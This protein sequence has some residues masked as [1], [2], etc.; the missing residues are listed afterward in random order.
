MTKKKLIIAAVV[1]AVIG[2]IVWKCWPSKKTVTFTTRVVVTDTVKSTVTATGSLAP[3]D[4]VEV[5]TQVSGEV[6]KIYVDYNSIVKKGQKLAELDKSTLMERLNQCNA[7]LQSALSTYTLAQ[8]NYSRTKSLYDQ[9]AATKSDLETVQ[10]ALTQ[11]QAQVT[12]AQTNV[13]EAKVNLGYAEIYSPIDGV[14]LGKAVEEGQTVASSFNTPTLFTIARDLKNMQVEANIDEADIGAVKKGQNVTFTVDSH[15][16][17]TFN[18]KVRQIRLDPKTTN[19][20]VTYTVI[21]EAPN[22]DEK[23]LPGMTASI[24]IITE[25]VADLVIPAAATKWAPSEEVINAMPR[26]KDKPADLQ[27]GRPTPD[28]NTGAT[29]TK[30]ANYKTVWVKKGDQIFPKKVALGLSDGVN[31]IVKSGISAGDSVITN[32]YVGEKVRPGAAGNNPFMPKG[33]QRGSKNSAKEAAGRG[34]VK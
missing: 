15:N 34:P 25:S 20:V 14:V 8:Q 3:V 7:S 18:G 1:L 19:N 22:P 32:A 2:L 24:T 30:D 4:K 13:R 27:E 33:P 10:N 28:T 5:G 17:L 26:P 31:Y 21:I 12:Q 6:K 23:L 29:T 11:A 16:G 9:K